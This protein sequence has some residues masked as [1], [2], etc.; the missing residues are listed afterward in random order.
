[1]KFLLTSG[2]IRNNSLKQALL[3]LAGKQSEDLAIAY[4]P[5]AANVEP[6]DKSWVIDRCTEFKNIAKRLFDI[7]DISAVPRDIWLSRLQ[8]VDVIVFG[9]GNTYHLI[10]QVRK[11]GLETEIPK[12]S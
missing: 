1:M 2:G 3:A 7:V 8:A 10:Y 11:S 9:G 6:R 12:L 4:I 5:T